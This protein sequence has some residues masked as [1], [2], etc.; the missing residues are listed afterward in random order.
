M[1]CRTYQGARL[2]TD[3]VLGAVAVLKE[4]I[5]RGERPDFHLGA[6]STLEIIISHDLR[7]QSEFI[8]VLDALNNENEEFYKVRKDK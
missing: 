5:A 3:D 1:L 2:D 8:E 4:R 7:D 6:L